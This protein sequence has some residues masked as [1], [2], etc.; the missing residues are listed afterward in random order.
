MSRR[1]RI[2]R[3]KAIIFG[4]VDLLLFKKSF[5]LLFKYVFGFIARNQHLLHAI[6]HLRLN[7]TLCNSAKHYLYV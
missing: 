6:D 4:D 5:Q 3:R 7:I 2:I 1:R